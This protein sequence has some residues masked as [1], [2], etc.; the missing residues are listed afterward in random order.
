MT[1]GESEDDTL[2]HLTRNSH[3]AV[4]SQQGLMGQEWCKLKEM[5][6]SLIAKDLIWRCKDAVIPVWWH[7]PAVPTHGWKIM[8][9]RTTGLHNKNTKQN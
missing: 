9:S 8:S 6:P 3:Q 5:I 1:T 2:I 4:N 7:V